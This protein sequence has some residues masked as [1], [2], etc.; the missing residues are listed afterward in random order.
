MP[1]MKALSTN[2]GDAQ[3]A[4]AALRSIVEDLGPFRTRGDADIVQWAADWACAVTVVF[5]PEATYSAARS[6]S[7]AEVP[8]GCSADVPADRTVK[9]SADLLARQVE[10]RDIDAQAR[11]LFAVRVL[12]LLAAEMTASGTPSAWHEASCV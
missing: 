10:L 1:A 4:L 9:A 7:L 8:G 2:F 12:W 5:A 3:A 11:Q 6:A